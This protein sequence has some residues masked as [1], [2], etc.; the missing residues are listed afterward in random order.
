MT[1]IILIPQMPFYV[2][3]RPK[4]INVL[5]AIKWRKLSDVNYKSQITNEKGVEV[6]R[7]CLAL[8]SRL[9]GVSGSK[10]N[11]RDPAQVRRASGF[12]AGAPDLHPL[13]GSCGWYDSASRPAVPPL[14]FSVFVHLLSGTNFSCLFALLNP[15]LVFVKVWKRTSLA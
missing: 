5:L 4:L 12:R 7:S 14:C 3:H 6:L 13:H 1:Y 10:V 15:W 11:D 8:S 2:E 9:T